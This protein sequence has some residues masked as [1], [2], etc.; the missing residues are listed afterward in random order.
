[1]SFKGFDYNYFTLGVVRSINDVTF[2]INKRC[3]IS[4]QLTLPYLTVSGV[5]G[6]NRSINDVTIRPNAQAGREKLDYL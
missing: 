4:D 3:N 5:E 1:M 2:K 6:S